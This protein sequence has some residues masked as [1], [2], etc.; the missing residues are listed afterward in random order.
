MKTSL[1]VIIALL[2]ISFV[3]SGCDDGD[4]CEPCG[5]KCCNKEQSCIYETCCYWQIE[6]DFRPFLFET[7]WGSSNDE[8]FA[9]GNEVT[10]SGGIRRAVVLYYDGNTWSQMKI[11]DN[12][13]LTDIWGSSNSDVY[14]VGGGIDPTTDEM[15]SYITHYD[16]VS[17]TEMLKTK[18]TN[19]YSYLVGIWGSSNSDIFAVGWNSEE[20]A[21]PEPDEFRYFV[22]HYDGTTWTEMMEDVDGGVYDVWGTSASNVYA[23]GMLGPLAT[24]EW[25][26]LHYEG[27]G[28]S[29]IKEHTYY[30]RAVWGSSENDIYVVGE[31]VLHYDGTDWS[32]I[33]TGIPSVNES[34]Y[35]ASATDIFL[36]GGTTIHY[37]GTMWKELEQAE[38]C[39]PLSIWKSQGGV[40]WAVGGY[41]AFR[42]VCQ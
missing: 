40:V 12:V 11:I 4:K 13:T 1:R 21:E 35:G 5:Q 38:E 3:V 7:I 26:I 33:D 34:I 9:V 15:F 20:L 10:G 29:I 16:G 27:N 25:V 2:G 6:E 23:V 18:E 36:A 17:W 37:D 31:N 39:C 8:M 24:P 41:Y 42:L 28:W 22:F 14:A 30:L 19:K 32:E